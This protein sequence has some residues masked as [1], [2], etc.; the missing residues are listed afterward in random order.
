MHSLIFFSFLQ[1]EDDL[2]H[3]KKTV[4]TS[5]EDFQKAMVH[6]DANKDFKFLRYHAE[7]LF[8]FIYWFVCR[9]MYQH[10]ELQTTYF[11]L[12]QKLYA[13]LMNK[14]DPVKKHIEHLGMI[15]LI[16]ISRVLIIFLRSNISI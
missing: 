7:T 10:L 4:G 11:L 15:N 6:L 8:M 14:I 2:N 5:T 13:N 9:Y 16:G 12:G 3:L 1:F